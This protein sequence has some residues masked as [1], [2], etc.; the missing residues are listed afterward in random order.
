MPNT[1]GASAD[2]R[3]TRRSRCDHRPGIRAGCRP[4]YRIVTEPELMSDRIP[5]AEFYRGIAIQDCQPRD[6]IERI[7]RPELDSVHSASDVDWLVEFADDPAHCPE[8]RMFAAAKVKALYTIAAEERRERPA[9]DL[10]RV[11]ASIA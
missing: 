1:A 11:E 8:A 7:V 6:R 3:E 4:A 2:W 9:V 5:T 10:D